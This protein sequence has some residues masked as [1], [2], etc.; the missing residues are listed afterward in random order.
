LGVVV[1]WEVLEFDR[2]VELAE[3]VGEEVGDGGFGA[4]DGGDVD[5]GAVEREEGVPVCG[6]L[7]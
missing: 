5:E 1:V 6:G 4:A 7:V 2:V 3:V